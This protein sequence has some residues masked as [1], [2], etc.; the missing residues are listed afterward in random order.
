MN[1][2][3]PVTSA[4]SD[5]DQLIIAQARELSDK[6]KQHRLEMFPPRAQKGLRPFQLAEAARFLGVTS[7]YLR[8]LSLE[9]KGPLPQVTPSGRRSY[10]AEQLQEMRAFLDENGRGSR[11]VPHRR[12][13]EHLQVIAVVNFKGGSGKTTSAAH[14]AQ[15]LALTGHRVLA[16]DL[17]P[18]ASLSAIHGLQPEFDL[19]ENETLY[20]AIRYDEERRPLKDVIRKTNFP[21]LDIVPGNLELMEF[22]HDTPRILAQGHSADYGRIFFARLDEALASVSDDYDVV[23]I[24]CPPQ[25]GFLTMSAICAATAVLITVHPQ[26]LDVM[27]MCQFLQMLGE[28]LNTLKGA[29]G[30]MK[31]DWLRYL[32]TRYD[33]QDGP[34]TQMVAFMRAMFRHHV[35][36]N[37]MLRSVAISDAALTNQTLYEIERQQ[38]TR[39]TYDRALESMDAVNGEILDLIHKAWGRK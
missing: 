18:Q 10:T 2:S 31:L 21:G 37:P 3:S 15:Y 1:M 28:V 8:N 33:P 35:L 38:F 11:Y 39:A 25:L 19:G 13:G 12:E 36:T 32:I 26:M 34:Q 24:D 17:D 16:V 7:G 20:A 4:V 27:S 6:L 14:L 23:V 30:N 22:E 29:G 9:G 5:V